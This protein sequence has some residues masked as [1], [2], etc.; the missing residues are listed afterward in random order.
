MK[1][2]HDFVEEPE[3]PTDPARGGLDDQLLGLFLKNYDI[4][5]FEPDLHT[6][7]AARTNVSVS[8]IAEIDPTDSPLVTRA[9]IP[10]AHLARD[11]SP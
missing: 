9:R 8:A 10:A 11:S 7:S 5:K 6:T 3:P 1:S 4:G 2:E